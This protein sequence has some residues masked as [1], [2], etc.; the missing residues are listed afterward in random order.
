[1]SIEAIVLDFDGLII[2]TETPIFEEWRS[3]YRSRGVELE[4]DVW[5]HSLGTQNGFDPF[6]HLAALT[7]TAVDREVLGPVMRERHWQRC[8]EQPLLPGV[9]PLLGEA[10]ELRLGTAVASSATEAWVEGWIRRHG[11]RGLFDCVCTREHVAR[12]KPAPDLF[13]LAASRLG[14]P[15]A[16]CIVFED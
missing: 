1:M 5:Q 15:P 13:L 8:A 3:V 6:A 11:I 16:S 2:D 14:V 7:G 12:V 10:R 4:L 9:E